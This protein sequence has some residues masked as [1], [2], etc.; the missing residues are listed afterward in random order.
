MTLTVAMFGPL[1][2]ACLYPNAKAL[3][4]FILT[5]K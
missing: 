2:A 1:F 5:R 3:V 4:I